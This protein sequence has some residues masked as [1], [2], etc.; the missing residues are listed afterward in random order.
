M[1]DTSKYQGPIFIRLSRVSSERDLFFFFRNGSKLG[2]VEFWDVD[3][4]D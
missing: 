2:N 1:A 3:G 4:I